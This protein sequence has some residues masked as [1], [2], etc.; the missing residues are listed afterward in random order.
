MAK[1]KFL[2][3]VEGSEDEPWTIHMTPKPAE[4]AQPESSVDEAQPVVS[5]DEPEWRRDMALIHNFRGIV[6]E[7]PD[8]PWTIHLTPKSEPPSSEPT[9][10]LEVDESEDDEKPELAT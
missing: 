9:Q 1:F 6:E 2:G 4:S 5:A 3:I 7:Q 10:T 8:E